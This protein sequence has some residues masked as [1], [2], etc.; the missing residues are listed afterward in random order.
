MTPTVTEIAVGGIH[1]PLIGGFFVA[2]ARVLYLVF[3]KA[4]E[5]AAISVSGGTRVQYPG[6]NSAR[7]D[8]V[9]RFDGR[10]GTIA[11]SFHHFGGAGPGHRPAIEDFRAA[12]SQLSR[13]TP[14]LGHAYSN[15][16]LNP[17]TADAKK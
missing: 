11:R 14:G 17:S 10:G 12:P 7:R 4:N 16:A 5:P 2:W 13:S 8:L 3:D 15:L 1:N 9:R 6:S